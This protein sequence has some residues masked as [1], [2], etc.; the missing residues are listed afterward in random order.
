MPRL[1]G[2]GPNGMGTMTGRGMGACAGG[3]GDGTGVG[4]RVGAGVGAGAG[5]RGGYAGLGFGCGCGRG[6]HRGGG[7]CF[8]AM[9]A[10]GVTDV[11]L[12]DENEEKAMLHLEATRLE[13]ELQR[14][15]GRLDSMG[16]NE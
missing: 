7:R 12:P 11:D 10:P 8:G 14:I 3:K 9:V 13:T 1:N 16:K 2:T 6:A 4:D 15:R 5:G